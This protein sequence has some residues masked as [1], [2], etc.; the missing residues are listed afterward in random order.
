M[1]THIL[2]QRLINLSVNGGFIHW[3]QD[4]LSD[5]PQSVSMNGIRSKKVVLN[6]GAP[7][8]CV[9]SPLLFSIYTDEMK[10]R[11][12]V[13]SLYKF[14]DDMALVGL[15]VREQRLCEQFYFDHVFA[16]QDWC[17]ASALQLNAGKTKELIVD[18][19]KASGNTHRPVTVGN[20]DVEVVESFKYLGTFIDS[21]FSFQNNTDYI[22]KK[23]MQRLFLLRKLRSFGVSGNVLETVYKSLIESVLSFNIS[24]WF[25]H[26]SVKNRSKLSRVVNIASK[27][28]GKS[29]DP[30]INI[31]NL[32]IKKKANTIVADQSHP[33]HACFEKLPSGRRFRVPRCKKNLYKK[34]FVPSAITVLN[35]N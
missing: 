22:F 25:G 13:V 5:R 23:A 18:F 35:S 7:Q 9:L 30:L 28:I 1:H 6:T 33:L 20:D 2:I 21:K 8:G 3:I 32:N 24:V 10:I 19:T 34:S 29:Q 14:A 4:F 11:N 31:Y 26:L 17:S 12:D 27:I 16:L 15:L